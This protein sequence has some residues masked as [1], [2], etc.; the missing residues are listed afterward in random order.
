MDHRRPWT[1]SEPSK[2][3]KSYS[4][5]TLEHAFL[6]F[7]SVSC[8]VLGNSVSH[9]GWGLA[10]SKFCNLAMLPR[11][12]FT[13]LNWS[14][15]TPVNTQPVPSSPSQS[16]KGHQ[17]PQNTCFLSL[18]T[19]CFA[20]LIILMD[21]QGPEPAMVAEG[22][23]TWV[24]ASGFSHSAFRESQC[25][26]TEC[27]WPLLSLGSLMVKIPLETLQH[28]ASTLLLGSGPR[29]PSLAQEPSSSAGR[30]SF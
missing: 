18:Q 14:P 29:F 4:L 26:V 22:P 9:S 12:A 2:P 21:P 20:L 10:S 23:G 1:V 13:W 8:L 19:T 17:R 7:N 25:E 6:C 30:F 24:L 28:P 27:R 15:S 3:A 11:G 16:L 5:T